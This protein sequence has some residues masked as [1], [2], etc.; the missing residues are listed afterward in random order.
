ML[1]GLNKVRDSRRPKQKI[2]AKAALRFGLRRGSISEAVTSALA[3]WT[4]E[5]LVQVSQT[6][7]GL[8]LDIKPSLVEDVVKLILQRSGRREFTVYA[9]TPLGCS[10]EGFEEIDKD[11]EGGFSYLVGKIN[12]SR[13]DLI[14]DL[15]KI[16]RGLSEMRVESGDFN[17]VLGEDGCLSVQ[18]L[19]RIQEGRVTEDILELHGVQV[20]VPQTTFEIVAW[21]TEHVEVLEKR[22]KYG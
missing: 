15:T 14:G 8:S 6:P 12:I 20:A 21:S 4:G 9:K 13:L 7:F 22:P 1:N 2:Q 16:L 10:L 17:I 19:S 11:V 18:G 5:P 3:K